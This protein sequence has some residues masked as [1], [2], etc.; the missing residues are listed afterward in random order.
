MLNILLGVGLGGAWMTMKSANQKHDKHPDRPLRYKPYHIEVGGT[1]MI[2]AITVLLTLTFLLVAVPMNK[3]IMSRKIGYCLIVI[4]TV[5]T[6]VNVIVELTG[7]W[8][9]VA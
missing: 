2:S 7:L 6:I 5:S 9:D 8:K 3:W 1:L 4:W